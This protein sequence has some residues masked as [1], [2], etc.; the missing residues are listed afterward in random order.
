MLK[1]SESMNVTLIARDLRQTDTRIL[2]QSFLSQWIPLSVSVLG[3]IF[4][5]YN[6]YFTKLNDLLNFKI[7]GMV[8]DKCPAPNELTDLKIENLLCPPMK[9]FNL[10]PKETVELKNDF[11]KCCADD[12]SVPVIAFVSKMF[13]VCIHIY[14][15]F[16]K[17]KIDLPI[18]S[19][20]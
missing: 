15:Y 17:K 13:P 1:I 14:L 18:F 10:M 6:F 2:L 20:I 4:H 16:Q 5:L 3:K 9:E 11:S 12:N 8:C 7:S 19:I